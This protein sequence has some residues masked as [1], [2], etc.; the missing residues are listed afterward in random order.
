M[1]IDDAYFFQFNSL[2]SIALPLSID[3]SSTIEMLFRITYN[4]CYLQF[5]AFS[6][7]VI[8]P[9]YLLLGLFCRFFSKFPCIIHVFAGGFQYADEIKNLQT[10]YSEL[11]DERKGL[12]SKLS[13]V[14]FYP[15]QIDR[16]SII[17]R[18]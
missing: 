15:N 12:K 18:H 13:E 3:A 17:F 2:G 10:K 9:F 16:S 6:G 14:R 8:L 1:N 11:E 4:I 7:P 5:S